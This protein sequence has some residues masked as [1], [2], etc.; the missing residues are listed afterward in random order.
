[1]K[2]RSLISILPTSGSTDRFER[3]RACAGALFGLVLAGLCSFL[4]QGQTPDA[5]W[6]IAPMGAS[7]V[8]LFAVPASPL[9]QPW[10]IMGGNVV[11][12]NIGGTCAKLIEAAW[13][14]AAIAGSLAI[15]AMFALRCLH[16]PSGAVALT[17]VLGGPAVHALGY[18]FVIFPVALNSLLLL[19]TALFFNN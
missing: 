19:L 8:L 17:A 1:M 10:A 15:A 18:G 4:M 9:A 3:M 13:L 11:A 12:A 5:V 16:P 14:P 6:L 7:A 2:L